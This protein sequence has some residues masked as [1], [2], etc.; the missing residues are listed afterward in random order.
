MF[1]EP[2]NYDHGTKREERIRNQRNTQMLEKHNNGNIGTLP[3]N[4]SSDESY[5]DKILS[6]EIYKNFSRESE[7]GRF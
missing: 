3:I 4:A 6:P 5:S 2:A 7:V 1:G